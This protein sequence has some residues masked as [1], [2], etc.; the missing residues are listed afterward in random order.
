MSGNIFY[1]LRHAETKLDE[2]IPVSKWIL[3]ENGQKQAEAL[4]EKEIFSKIDVI[5]VSKENKAYQTALPLA[6]ALN[7][8]INQFAELNELTRDEEDHLSYEEYQ[9]YVNKTLSNI[10]KPVGKWESGIDALTRFSKKIEEINSSY[11]KKNILVITH[12][13]IINLYFGKLLESF[14]NLFQR[15]SSTTFCDFGIVKNNKVIKDI[16][17]E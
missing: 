13:L 9:E 12:G 1:H 3:S 5:I 16:A 14:Q 2:T 8:P 11:T 4:V 15:W 10:H 17:K 6:K 7:L